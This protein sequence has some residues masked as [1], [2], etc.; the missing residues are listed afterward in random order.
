MATIAF[1]WQ[2]SPD[3]FR[4]VVVRIATRTNLVYQDYDIKKLEKYW[5][6]SQLWSGFSRDLGKLLTSGFLHY[7]E[8]ISSFHAE[9]SNKKSQ[10]ELIKIPHSD[11]FANFSPMKSTQNLVTWL[12]FA[13][14]SYSKN[15]RI[16]NE[17]KYTMSIPILVLSTL[18]T[19]ERIIFLSCA[20]FI[21][22]I[23]C[24]DVLPNV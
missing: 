7:V 23:S 3:C 6:L 12:H 11:C 1:L 22:N 9:S 17:F 24:I 21:E 14:N 18:I 8:E 10:R 5:N 16:T 19:H 2:S 13:K 20:A 15:E 4:C